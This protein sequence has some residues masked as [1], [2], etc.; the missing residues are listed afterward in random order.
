M[1]DLDNI[2]SSFEGK[3][4]ELIPVLQKIQNELG[5]LSEE[6]ML[7]A[8]EFLNIPESKVF[9]VA[10]FYSQFRFTP[11][12]RNKITVCEGTACHVKGAKGI[13]E[14]ISR[15]KGIEDGETSSCMEYT[16]EGVACIGCCALAPCITIND[17]VHG[18]LDKKKVSDILKEI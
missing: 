8:A 13:K 12:G 18:R 2:L 9:G 14:E 5:Y 15:I 4:G 7:R 1:Q 11:T 3:S 10:S 6:A 16:L 17:D